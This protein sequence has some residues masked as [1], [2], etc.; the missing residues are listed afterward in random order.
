MKKVSFLTF[1]FAASAISA[2]ATITIQ[3]ISNSAT[4]L[5]LDSSEQS[6][7]ETG[8]MRIGVFDE[9]A[10]ELLSI[11]E[12]ADYDTVD[13]LFTEYTTFTSASGN[14]L[15]NTN[16]TY[17]GTAGENLYA[18]VFNSTSPE[19]ADEYAIFGSSSWTV[20][21]DTGT[22]NLVSSQINNVVF[23][24]TIAGSPT[25][26]ALSPVPEPSTFAAI[27]GVLALGF[28]ATRRRRA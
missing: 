3:A 18:W 2:N 24:S 6:L 17:P 13:S 16:I 15:S 11:S 14:F 22:A 12:L 28:T 20:P 5:I 23:G 10:L 1:I 26:Y 7:G 27:A 21:N 8:Y 4:G 9:A 25:N 19:S